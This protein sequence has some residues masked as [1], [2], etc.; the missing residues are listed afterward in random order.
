MVP[1]DRS[2]RLLLRLVL[3]ELPADEVPVTG[4]EPGVIDLLGTISLQDLHITDAPATYR[5]GVRNHRIGLICIKI[6]AAA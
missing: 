6:Q 1:V 4:V 2:T 5:I 3:L